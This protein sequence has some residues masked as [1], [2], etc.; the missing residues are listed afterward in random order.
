MDV[1]VGG[2]EGCRKVDQYS[3]ADCLAYTDRQR[4]ENLGVG[5]CE[6][7][8]DTK[9]IKI[10]L[11]W[12]S[13]HD[14]PYRFKEN[15]NGQDING[16]DLRI[17]ATCKNSKLEDT[18][19]CKTFKYNDCSAG[20]SANQREMMCRLLCEDRTDEHGA[21]CRWEKWRKDPKLEID[22]TN[23]SNYAMSRE[24]GKVVLA[25]DKQNGGQCE[26]SDSA[27]VLHCEE[28]NYQ[29]VLWPRTEGNR[30]A[31]EPAVQGSRWDADGNCIGAEIMYRYCRLER[32]DVQWSE[33]VETWPCDNGVPRRRLARAG[34]PASLARSIELPEHLEERLSRRR[35]LEDCVTVHEVDMGSGCEPICP[36]HCVSCRANAPRRLLGEY[37]W[38]GMRSYP[39]PQL[40]WQEVLERAARKPELPRRRLQ[41]G[42]QKCST[43]PDDPWNRFY[44]TLSL[45][46]I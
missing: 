30:W 43:D 12:T 31:Q 27:G 26:Y 6:W 40:A 7:M 4:C 17:K 19:P 10:V 39:C 32:Q 15:K 13:V 38:D 16:W 44:P 37:C 11:E 18:A 29:G 36:A 14:A 20:D 3:D 34:L 22:N 5:R 45:I 24:L 9:P 23:N 42:V 46:H 28:E 21:S 35:L 41:S 33:R 1:N 8:E 2:A 25:T